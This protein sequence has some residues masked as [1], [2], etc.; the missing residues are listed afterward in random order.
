MLGIL[1]NLGAFIV[2]LGILIA[3]HE[4][5]HFWVARKCGVKVERFSIGFGKTLFRKVGND[6]CEYVIAAIPLGGYVK[7][8]DERVE[9]VPESLKSQAFNRKSVWK[10][11]AIIAA[12]PLA[13][14][15]FAVLAYY[16][17]LVIGV[18]SIKPVIVNVEA[19]SPA[20][21]IQ[22]DEPKQIT[23]ISGRSVR[24]WEEA[25][26][27]I[28]GHIGDSSIE[29]TVEPVSG[30]ASATYQ[31]DSSTWKFDPET[32]SPIT[33][34]GLVPFTPEISNTIAFV[35]EGSAAA[36]AGLQVGD[37][38]I[39]L[40]GEPVNSWQGFV[41]VI[42]RSPGVPLPLE[43]NREGERLQVSLTPDSETDRQGNVSGRIGIAPVTAQWP[44]AMQ[45][46]LSFGPFEAIGAA[47]DKTW[48]MMGL[49]LGMLGKLFTGDIALNNLSGPISIAQGAG[50]SAGYGLVYFLGFLA[51]ISVNL[52][53]INLLPLPVLDGGH[54][55]YNLVEIVTGKPVPENVQEIG[56]RIGAATLLV[57]M[58]FA[59][60]N[61]IARL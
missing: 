59:I 19:D 20:Q 60:F 57:V 37:E 18:P 51:L 40:G 25:Q 29:V 38:L 35:A 36:K 42:K 47:A 9:D 22:V 5:G 7:M 54:L 46:E 14:F 12:G 61:D 13:N 17:M 32:E 49:T 31:L 58:G 8:L 44:E 3:I 28:I 53:I 1:W 11:S 56:F 48:H 21:V 55:L 16:A 10:R 43:I 15:G 23:A 27:A 24:N 33:S 50:S 2:A 6:G 30:G 34:L 4:Y 52:G 45:I 41:D 39:L 26:M